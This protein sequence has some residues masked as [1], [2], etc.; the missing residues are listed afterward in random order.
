VQSCSACSGG[1]KVGYLGDGGTLTFPD[2]SAAAAGAYT[3]TVNY[4]DGD[5]GRSATITVNG[6]ASTVSFTGTDNGNWD[7]VQSLTV[8]VTLKAGTNTIEF[9]NSSG[10]APDI[11]QITLNASSG[12]GSSGTVYEANASAN[13][14]AGGAVAQS[15]SAC[16]DGYKV[17]YLGDG[18]TLTFPDV[19]ETNAGSYT[20]TIYYVDGDAG[21]S[22]VIT[23]NGSPT[24]VSFTGTNNGNWD[25]VQSLTVPVTLNAGTNTI[26][27][28]NPSAYAPDIDHIV[29]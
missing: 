24:T 29:V 14:L 28:S 20:M 18:G 5:A 6:S 21:R 19:T 8:P 15:C 9:S 13:V 22:A 12:S 10:Y 2:V 11:D 7:T 3:M 26:E 1:Q 27:F 16:L 25:T 17:G 23:V 4:V